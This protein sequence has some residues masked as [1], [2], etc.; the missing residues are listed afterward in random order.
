MPTKPVSILLSPEIA[1]Q[2]PAD[3]ADRERVLVLGLRVWHIRRVLAAY[4]RGESSLAHA[5]EQ[6]GVPLREMI[7]LAYAHGLQPRIAPELEAKHEL[8][9]EEAADL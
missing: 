5:A 4:Q 8:S 6:A 2:L 3:P 7:A 9:L 1:D